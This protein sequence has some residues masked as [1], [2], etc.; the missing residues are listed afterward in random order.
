MSV[1]FLAAKTQVAPLSKVTIPQLE[2]L[3]ALLLS[4]LVV[5][6]RRALV[7]ELKLGDPVSYSDSKVAL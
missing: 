2:L 1:R 5:T 6:V 7:L 4:K 3:S